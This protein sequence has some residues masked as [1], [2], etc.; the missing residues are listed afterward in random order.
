VRRVRWELFL[1][2]LSAALVVQI[3]PGPGMLFVLAN[4]IAGGPRAGIAAACGAATGMVFH[5]FAAALGLAALFSHAPVAY[6]ALRIAGGLYLLWLAIGHF[7]SAS[8]ALV[9]Q[10]GERRS[11][12]QVFLGLLASM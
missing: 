6:D 9:G 3:V 10:P 7:R 12:R 1:S 11:P 2:F 4:G 5:T 8:H